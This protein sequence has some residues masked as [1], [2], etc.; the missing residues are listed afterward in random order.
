MSN[1]QPNWC[2]L[3]HDGVDEGFKVVS[4]PAN[5][6]MEFMYVIEDMKEKCLII[7]LR[8]HTAIKFGGITTLSIILKLV[9]YAMCI[10]ILKRIS[11]AHI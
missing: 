6:F 7:F 4:V 9:W 3:K 10:S 5:F 11:H 8:I 1:P 2:L